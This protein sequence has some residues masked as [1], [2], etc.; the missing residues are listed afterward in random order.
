[1]LKQTFLVACVK[2]ATLAC[3]RKT[4]YPSSWFVKARSYVE[5]HHA[6]WFMEQMNTHRH[7]LVS[8]ERR[9]NITL[10]LTWVKLPAI[11]NTAF[12]MRKFGLHSKICL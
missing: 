7:Q 4:A 5:R 12:N 8:D 2:E 9:H 3:T 1:M 11:I 6:P 10:P